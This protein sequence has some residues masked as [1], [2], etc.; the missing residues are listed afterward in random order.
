MEPGANGKEV[1]EFHDKDTLEKKYSLTATG[2]KKTAVKMGIPPPIIKREAK[3]RGMTREEAIK[4]LQAVVRYNSFPGFHV[5]FELKP[6]Y[7]EDLSSGEV[8]EEVR[9]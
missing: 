7:K 4:K 9:K 6:K 3:R 8:G 1:I 5:S 2:D